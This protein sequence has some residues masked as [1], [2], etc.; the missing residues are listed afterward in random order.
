MEGPTPRCSDI[1]ILHGL[2]RAAMNGARIIPALEACPHL[3]DRLQLHIRVSDRDLGA[4][5]QPH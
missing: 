2:P 4:H 1:T 3:I 5:G